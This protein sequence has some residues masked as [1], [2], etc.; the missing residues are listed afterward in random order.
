MLKPKYITG[1][2]FK[3][4]KFPDAKL[5][6]LGKLLG[7]KEAICFSYGHGLTIGINGMT[8]DIPST[9]PIKTFTDLI[10]CKEFM[11]E[12][13]LELVASNPDEYK[14]C[15]EIDCTKLV[16]DCANE[17]EVDYLLDDPDSFIWECAVYVSNT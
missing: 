2:D 15:G 7:G 10:M 13:M 8:L 4:D 5:S 16:E 17:F 3:F 12:Q 1:T 9:D 11:I 14:N 6:K